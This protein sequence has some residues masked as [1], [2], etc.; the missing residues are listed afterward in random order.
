MIITLSTTNNLILKE[1]TRVMIY[2]FSEAVTRATT[3]YKHRFTVTHGALVIPDWRWSHPDDQIVPASI[4]Q[5]AG[6][7]HV[8]STMK[9]CLTTDM[10]VL[11]KVFL[12]S[13]LLKYDTY[14]HIANAREV[15]L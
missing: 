3:L 15:L 6:T 8:V 9:D 5:W 10:F 2:M 14:T 4:Q 7:V 13:L 12:P 11:Y 1:L